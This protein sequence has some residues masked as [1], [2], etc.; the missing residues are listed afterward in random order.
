MTGGYSSRVVFPSSPSHGVLGQT[1]PS[2]PY[3]FAGGS[4]RPDVEALLPC[5]CAGSPYPPFCI[6][7]RFKQENS[8][9]RMYEL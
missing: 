2:L 1:K 7:A 5:L 9:T 8:N 6:Y 3:A 4:R